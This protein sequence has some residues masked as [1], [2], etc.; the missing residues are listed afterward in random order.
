MSKKRKKS[1]AEVAG[2][3]L[4]RSLG[5]AKRRASGKLWDAIQNAEGTVARAIGMR[6]GKA[7]KK[8]KPKAP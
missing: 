8:P 6:G 3:T 4:L 1:S 5:D 2:K 7:R